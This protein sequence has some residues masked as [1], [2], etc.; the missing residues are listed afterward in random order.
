MQKREFLISFI[1]VIL[2]ASLVS[3]ALTASIDKP[4]MVLYK[5]ISSGK[6]LEFENSVI[7][8]NENEYDVNILITPTGNWTD[9]VTLQNKEFVLKEGESKEIFYTIKIDKEG[10]YSGDI[11]V[12]FK[13]I[14]TNTDISIAQDLAVI[15]NPVEKNSKNILLPITTGVAGI[16]ILLII[17]K[18]IKK[19]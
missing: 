8:N 1:L 4:R 16:L 18:V 13:D 11:L 19:K 12:T 3:S 10:Y 2:T 15:V 7:A 9:R 14:E 6:I 17:I 5:N